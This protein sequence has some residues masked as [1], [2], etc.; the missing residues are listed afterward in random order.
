[1]KKTALLYSIT[2]IIGTALILGLNYW[3]TAAQSTPPPTQQTQRAPIATN[4]PDAT[5]AHDTNAETATVKKK[6]CVCCSDRMERFKEQ[7]RKARQRKQQQNTNG[8]TEQRL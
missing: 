3:I 5:T 4:T 1:M 2:L 6:S 8:K 7:I